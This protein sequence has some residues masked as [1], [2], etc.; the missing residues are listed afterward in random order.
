MDCLRNCLCSMSF[1]L[2]FCLGISSFHKLFCYYPP[3]HA[4]QLS[5]NPTSGV[6][7]RYEIAEDSPNR[8]EI[9]QSNLALEK[10]APVLQV[11]SSSS[12]S[13]SLV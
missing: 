11:T 8:E 13:S 12:W 6:E 4:S 5:D 7:T 1:V 3:E 2:V 9:L 10:P